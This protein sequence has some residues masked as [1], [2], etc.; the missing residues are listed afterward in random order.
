MR[1]LAALLA[2]TLAGLLA[3]SGWPATAQPLPAA[4]T[5]D[6]VWVVVDFGELGGISTQC[7]TSHGTGAKALRSAGFSPTIDG[8]FVY[9][10]DGL[11]EKPDANQAY[12]SY[13]QAE[14]RSDGSFGAWE[15][16]NK[17][18]NSSK[19][20]RGNAEGWRYQ[21]LADGKVSP[22]ANPPAE[23]PEPSATPKPKPT[24]PAK[25]AKPKPA[26]TA[27]PKPSKPA[28]PEPTRPAEPTP[29]TTTEPTPAPGPTSPSAE[30][31]PSAGSETPGPAEDPAPPGSTTDPAPGPG[32]PLPAIVAGVL[33]VAGGGA[34]GLWWWLKGRHR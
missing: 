26:R 14:R 9:R 20:G 30:S 23:E 4:K 11:P 10:I 33:V 8:G 27:K 21:S 19:P 1:R 18:A 16:S 31:S 24:K 3:F 13:W 32:S 6:G 5:C 12:W 22:G 34:A 28:A 15:Y 7:A 29:T 25:P 2:V 17:G